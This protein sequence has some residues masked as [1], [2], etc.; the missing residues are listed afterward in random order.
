MS[1]LFTEQDDRKGK[2]L[3]RGVKPNATND[4]V[5]D[6]LQM[7]MQGLFQCISHKEKPAKNISLGHLNGNY[8]TISQN[9][10]GHSHTMGFSNKGVITFYLEEAAFL[11]ARNALIVYDKSEKVL[12]FE[13]FCEMICEESDSWITYDKYQV[14]AYL[15]R[16]GFI[17][18]RSK[19]DIS[20]PTRI[21][22]FNRPN[23]SRR[24]PVW[25]Y[26]YKDYCMYLV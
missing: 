1:I 14:Y 10:G 15:K 8:V 25:D 21:N 9:K 19:G 5:D 3:K 26:L 2:A 11:T 22:Y 17:V 24:L 4:I 20:N 23:I 12:E 7:A 13:D 18:M 16:L 6:Q